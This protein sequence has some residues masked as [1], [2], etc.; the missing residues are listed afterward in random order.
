MEEIYKSLQVYKNNKQTAL[1]IKNYF[2][3]GALKL[4]DKNKIIMDLEVS[5]SLDK[6][7]SELDIQVK[8]LDTVLDENGPST[9]NY[10]N[11]SFIR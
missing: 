11:F 4:N 7:M 6:A 9:S 2:S 1:Q 8:E 5:N 10:N 3:S